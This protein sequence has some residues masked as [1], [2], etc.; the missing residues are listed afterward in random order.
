[1]SEV[2]SG[3]NSEDVLLFDI[4]KMSKNYRVSRNFTLSELA[5]RDGASVVLLH[6]ALI[7]G[8]QALRDYVKAS[9]KINSGYRSKEHNRAINGAS[10]SYH[11]LG[12]AADVVVTGYTPNQIAFIAKELG[13]GGVK[14][15]KTFTHIDVGPDRTW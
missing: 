7:V 10:A 15:Y 3:R 4:D 12:M 9:V 11:V 5:S 14:A 13:F 8:L 6:P 2:L 1:M